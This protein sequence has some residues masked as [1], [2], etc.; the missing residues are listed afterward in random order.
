M[1]DLNSV[2]K[3]TRGYLPTWETDSARYHIVMRLEDSIPEAAFD[4]IRSDACRMCETLVRNSKSSEEAWLLA[5][6]VANRRIDRYLDRGEG[7][8]ALRDPRV[9]KMVADA[10]EYF[11]TKRYWLFDWSV[12]PNHVHVVFEAV[13]ALEKIMHS[14]KSF[15]GLEANR[16][17]GRTGEFWQKEQWNRMIRDERELVRTIRYV[18]NNPAKA[19]LRDWEW[20]KVYGERLPATSVL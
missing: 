9:A 10:L 19:G 2:R 16:I 15:T 12:M 17:L 18:A 5:A 3:R 11:D 6:A 13:D 14:W 7:S 20:V 4:R 1:L 8:C